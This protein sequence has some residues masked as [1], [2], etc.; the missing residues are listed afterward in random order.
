M[1]NNFHRENKQLG[2]EINAMKLG[3]FC[4]VIN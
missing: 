1:I 3:R 4:E 2:N